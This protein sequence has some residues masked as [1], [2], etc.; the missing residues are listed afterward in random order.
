MVIESV[1]LMGERDKVFQQN[2]KIFVIYSVLFKVMERMY[3]PYAVKFL[4]RIGG[5]EFHISLFNALPGF[6]MFLT[7]FMGTVWLSQQACKKRAIQV[8]ILVSRVIILLFAT[9]P[10]MPKVYQPM[11]FVIL[12]GLM[13]VPLAVYLAGYQSFV[14]DVFSEKNR[15]LAIG[16]GNQYGVYA[17]MAVTL[18]TGYILSELPGNESE[19]I[20]I[21]QIFFVLSFLFGVGEILIFEKFKLRTPSQKKVINWRT[22]LRTIPHN[23]E[24]KLFMACSLIF[25]FGWQMGWPLFS[26]YMIK[27]L[28]A[29]EMWLAIINMGSFLTMII[30]HK[31]WPGY[32]EKLG[33]PAVTAICTMGMA[34]TPL[35]YIVSKNLVVM[36]VVAVATGI[37]TSGTLTVLLSGLLEV[38]PSEERTVY[39][40]FY[41]TFINLSLAIA[42]MVGHAF[43]QGR[44]IVFALYMTAIFRLFGGVAF[45]V[46][47][48]HIKKIKEKDNKEMVS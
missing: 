43:M 9:V 15:A 32:I 13:S 10:M 34:L 40:G 31:I 27:V 37:F 16:K 7:V 12:S 38:L 11:G 25:H 23:K 22:T 4:E 21:Y 42:P 14:G 46:R 20:F 17:V 35:L 48:K 3:K 33:N 6:M 19:R 36:S 24:F 18:L 28:G 29:N 41:N 5:S 26:I 47:S 45:I 8:T 1:E 39:M 44:G 30:G 2:L